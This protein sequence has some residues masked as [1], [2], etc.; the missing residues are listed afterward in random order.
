MNLLKKL[1]FRC[2]NHCQ[3]YYSNAGSISY[4]PFYKLNRI[5]TSMIQFE[6]FFLCSYSFLS[7]YE[8]AFGVIGTTIELSI[9]PFSFNKGSAALRANAMFYLLIS[10]LDNFLHVFDML[11]IGSLFYECRRKYFI[12]NWLKL[13]L[14]YYSG[15]ILKNGVYQIAIPHNGA[16]AFSI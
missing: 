4:P 8:V 6:T 11:F 9:F 5:S 12:N 13:C 7:Y 3:H 2:N 10:C 14:R 15:L 1:N 16:S